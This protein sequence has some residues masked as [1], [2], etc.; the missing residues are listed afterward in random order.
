MGGN[1]RNKGKQ[2]FQSER[3]KVHYRFIGKLL[4]FNHRICDLIETKE[5]QNMFH[6]FTTQKSKITKHE[7]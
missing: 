5:M 7:N 1:M 2:M 6:G 4:L 3:K